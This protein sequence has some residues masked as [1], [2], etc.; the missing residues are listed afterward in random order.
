MANFLSPFVGGGAEGAVL[1][2]TRRVARIAYRMPYY[3][4][5]VRS[6]AGRIP[7]ST[8]LRSHF[9]FVLPDSPKPAHLTLE[10]TNRCNLACTYCTSPLGLRSRGM[11]DDETFGLLVE[12]IL[13]FDLARV[14]VVGNGEPTLHP[15]FG[16]MIRV[17]GK[18]CS[19]LNLVTN[20]HQLSEES[21]LA[22][23]EAPVRLLEIS[24]DSDNKEAY[25]LSRKRGNFERLV[26]NIAH[27]RATRD[28]IH[29]PAVL[30]IRV[31]IRPSE[32]PR[33]REILAF[34]GEKA[35]VAIPQY[36]HDYTHGNDADVFDHTQSAGAIPRCSLPTKAM[37][38][39]WNGRVPVCELSQQQTGIP[40]GLIAG[41]VH[42][43]TL[44]EIWN[45][46]LFVQ[47]RE[48]HRKRL[49]ELTPI[50]HGCFGG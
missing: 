3:A 7:P 45:S 19:Y 32:R 30:A 23:L 47:Y 15:K 17:L 43:S 16:E 46:P 18:S 21:A 37:I 10:F 28:R 42:T 49:A 4:R 33:E 25:E 1:D 50:C 48:G 41:D 31:M 38:V 40:E 24:V 44:Q 34:W 9:P 13:E 11:L 2:N 8:M 29:A 27:L 22:I 26:E 12:Q 20:A 14:C 36:V 39:H 5:I 6:A 35:D